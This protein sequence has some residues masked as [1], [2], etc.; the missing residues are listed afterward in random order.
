MVPMLPFVL[1]C[2]AFGALFTVIE[3]VSRRTPW[4]NPD[5]TRKAVHILSGLIAA[6]LPF[7]L[8]FDQISALGLFFIGFM[9]VSKKAHLFP[10]IHGV[11]RLTLGE[12]YYPLALAIVAWRFPSPTIYSYAILVLAL[13]DG[14]AAIIG[15]H[16]GMHTY[17]VI[18]GKKSLEGSATCWG[19]TLVL[20]L[21]TL[22]LSGEPL[23]ALIAASLGSATTIT[24][25]E[26]TLTGGLDN[27]ALPL[28]AALILSLAAR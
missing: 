23:S 1:S 9:A 22:A 19:I 5:D 2:L 24:A 16:I 11:R 7:W 3:I 25:A 15:T 4:L 28:I 6:C 27:L 26:A 14:F 20:T 12:I 10:S 21:F 8:S 18:G 13:S 17:R